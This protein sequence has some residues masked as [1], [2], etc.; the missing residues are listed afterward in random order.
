MLDLRPFCDLA[1][2]LGP[3]LE[4]GA[5]L[6]GRRRIIPITGGTVRGERLR[7]EVLPGGAD[8]QTVYEDGTAQLEARYTLRLDDGALIDV[9]NFGYRHG[10]PEIL[11]ALAR[12][13]PVDPQRYTMR[14]TPRFETGD[15]RHAWLNRTLFVATGARLPDAV[16]L[17]VHEIL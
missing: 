6:R 16:E 3:P 2:H 15:P 13:E 4:L 7:G 9:S 14:T 17:S 8:W 5:S 11:A 12:G 1:I 10:P